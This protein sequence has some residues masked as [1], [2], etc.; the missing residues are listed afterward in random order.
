MNEKWEALWYLWDGGFLALG[1]GGGLVP[2]HE[3][4]AIQVTL[5]LEEPVG[6]RSE[7]EPWSLYPGAIVAPDVT[8]QFRA[9]GG[10][11]AILFVDPESHE[12]RW[13]TRSLTRPVTEIPAA[14]LER[15]LPA[16]HSVWTDPVAASTA[17]R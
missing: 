17:I 16:L 11:I 7:D 5:G 4:H 13:L 10:L 15:V 1:R 2:P 12:G 3:H 14:K 9:P 8:H 6:L